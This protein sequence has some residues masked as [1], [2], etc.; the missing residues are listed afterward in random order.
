MRFL[1][2]LSL[3]VAH[4]Q[5]PRNLSAVP[6]VVG[7][8]VIIRLG[9]T[10]SGADS[11]LTKNT[12]PGEA[13]RR[14]ATGT[15]ATKDSFV[16]ARPAGG[17]QLGGNVCVQ[18]KKGTKLSA[19]KCTPWNYTEDYPAPPDPVINGV[20]VDTTGN[21]TGTNEPAGYVTVV[22]ED[23]AEPTITVESGR[24]NKRYTSVREQGGILAAGLTG[25]PYSLQVA[26]ATI[27]PPPTGSFGADALRVGSEDGY[28]A[29]IEIPQGWNPGGSEAPSQW[30][31]E[32]GIHKP[33]LYL[34]L[35]F[36]LSANYAQWQGNKIGYIYAGTKSPLFIAMEPEG[37]YTTQ[38]AAQT[39]PIRIRV[40]LQGVLPQPSTGWQTWNAEPNLGTSAQ[41][42]LT[43]DVWHVIEM[44]LVG[45][46]TGVADGA[47][48]LWLNGVLIIDR[49]DVGYFGGSNS[50]QA[51]F[52]SWSW[53]PTHNGF[54]G[55]PYQFS[56]YQAVDRL[57]ISV[58]SA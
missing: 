58:P 3:L 18:T 13:H 5:P 34:M 12:S 33:A 50:S 29:A 49:R 27:T 2:L 26:P 14:L 41:W 24:S 25:W 42:K 45:N 9:Y 51:S 19:E 56:V 54:N 40:G 4:Q 35:R 46:S 37:A 17:V 52:S 7:P 30:G 48:R 39:R 38:A 53:K 31:S 15:A 8:N 32:G 11:V 44:H 1:A 22:N 6:A 47:L 10:I 23:F 57:Y 16:V 28:L 21:A 55:V 36:K 20:T 43:R